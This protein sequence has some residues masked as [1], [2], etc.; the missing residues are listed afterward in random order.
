MDRSDLVSLCG[1]LSVACM[2]MAANL[3]RINGDLAVALQDALQSC[4][5]TQSAIQTVLLVQDGTVGK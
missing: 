4:E 5:Q 1:N 3:E 2:V